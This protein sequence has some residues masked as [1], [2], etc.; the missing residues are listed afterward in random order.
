[1]KISESSAKRGNVGLRGKE[2]LRAASIGI[3]IAQL[4]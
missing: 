4:A 3:L 1:M 2:F